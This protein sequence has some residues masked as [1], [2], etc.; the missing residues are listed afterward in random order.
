MSDN[1]IQV[2][3]FINNNVLTDYDSFVETGEKYENAALVIND[4]LST[5][6]ERAQNLSDIMTEMTSAITTIT[7]SV[8][9]S[10]QAINIS[11][12]SA[13]EIVLEMQGIGEAIDQNNEVTGKL[14]VSTQRFVNL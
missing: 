14:N 10:S 5:F 13:T 3:D 4:M 7:E 6:E 2:V 11:A 8:Q 1:A 9:E 12:N